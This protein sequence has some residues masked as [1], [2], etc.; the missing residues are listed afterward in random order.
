MEGEGGEGGK[1]TRK[2]E[3]R[4]TKASLLPAPLFVSR[5]VRLILTSCQHCKSVT[6]RDLSVIK[7]DLVYSFENVALRCLYTES[8]VTVV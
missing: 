3:T 5:K 1:E 7:A 4:H 8:S 6:K 2:G